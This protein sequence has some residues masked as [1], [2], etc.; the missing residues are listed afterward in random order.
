MVMSIVYIYWTGGLDSTYRVLY[1]LFILK[2]DVQPIYIYGNIDHVTQKR[3]QILEIKNLNQLFDAIQNLGNKDRGILYPIQYV[4]SPKLSEKT[5]ELYRKG[6]LRRPIT[7][8]TYCLEFAKQRNIVIE[9]CTLQTDKL[10]KYIFQLVNVYKIGQLQFP[11]QHIGKCEI[12]ALSD[13]RGWLSLLQKTMSC[14]YHLSYTESC[15]KCN[16]YKYVHVYN[17]KKKSYLSEMMKQKRYI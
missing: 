8:F 16:E 17:N 1:I 4:S 2:C 3:N 6:I 9:N 7:Q 11:L 14:W 12:L 5:I 15:K 13:K 10:G